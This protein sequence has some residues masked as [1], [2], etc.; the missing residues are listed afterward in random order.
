[1]PFSS[2]LCLL[3]TTLLLSSLGNAAA[4]VDVQYYANTGCLGSPI[5]SS[6]MTLT[7]GPTKSPDNCYYTGVCAPVPS[8]VTFKS[9]VVSRIAIALSDPVAAQCTVFTYSDALCQHVIDGVSS[10]GPLYVGTGYPTGCVNELS[11]T[12]PV[13]AQAFRFVCGVSSQ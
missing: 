1:M 5:N 9:F 7:Q 11:A 2:K 12:T 4:N 6:P 8:G 3:F 10:A 13:T